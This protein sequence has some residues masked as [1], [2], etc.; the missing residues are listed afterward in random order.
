MNGKFF[1]Y[2]LLLFSFFW[3]QQLFA[4]DEVKAVV[5]GTVKNEADNQRMTGVNVRVF[6]NGQPYLNLKTDNLGKYSTEL[7]L[8][9]TYEI[10][11]EQAEFLSK[12]ILVD[13]QN[14]PESA[15]GTSFDLLFDGTLFKGPK[16]FNKDVLKE[17]IAKAK[18]TD[19]NGKI[20]VDEGH[21][22]KRKEEIKEEIKRLGGD[23][24]QMEKDFNQL[25]IEGDAKMGASKWGE[26]VDKYSAA[27]KIFPHKDPAESKYKD[28]KAKFDAE[29]DAKNFE[30]KY[31]LL[32]KDG[33][34]LFAQDKYAESKVKFVEANKMKPKEVHP[35]E[36]LAELEGLLAGD[37]NKAEYDRQ[38]ADAD[39]KFASKFYQPAIDAYKSAS[40]LLPEEKYPK[41]KI[42]ECE[43]LIADALK[44]RDEDVKYQRLKDDA[45]LK[46]NSKKYEEAI[47]L[48]E[49]AKDVKPKET[50]P[51]QQIVKANDLIKDRDYQILKRKYDE[52]VARGDQKF[53]VKDFEAS[54]PIYEEAKAVLP[55]ELVAGEKI[56]A[57]NKAI[58]DRD[59][60]KKRKEYTDLVAKA[61]NQFKSTDFEQAVLNYESALELYASEVYPKTQIIESKRLQVEK[62]KKENQKAY[63]DLVAKADAK[64]NVEN[65][66]ESI[67]IYEQASALLT[68]EKYPGLQIVKANE[69]IVKRDEKKLRAQFDA[70]VKQADEKFNSS[71]FEQSI[72]IYNQALAVLGSEKY[73]KDQITKAQEGITKR[74]EKKLRGEFDAIVKQADEK[75]NSNNY[76]QSIDTYNQALALLPSEKYPKD[77]ITKAQEGITKRDE[78]KL[79]GEFDAIVQQADEK[80]NSGIYEQSIDIYNQALALLPS[81]KYPKDQITKAMGKMDALAAERLKKEQ[82]D[83]LLLDGDARLAANEFDEC[84][85][86]YKSAGELFPKEIYPK[87][88]IKKAESLIADYK[89]KKEDFDKLV[90]KGDGKFNG[91]K[92][93]ESIDIYNQALLLLP[94]ESYPKEQIIAATAKMDVVAAEKLKRQ[95]YDE[96][97][98]E[99]DIKYKN[100]DYQMAS[101]TYQQAADLYSDELYPP[102]QI[103][104]CLLMLNAPSEI[105]VN[106]EPKP[107]KLTTKEY[108]PRQMSRYDA[109]IARQL[110]KVEEKKKRNKE[111]YQE[112]SGNA[113]IGIAERNKEKQEKKLKTEE[114]IVSTI[115]IVDEKTYKKGNETVTEITVRKAENYSTYRKAAKSFATYYSEINPDTGIKI[116][117][118]T[119]QEWKRVTGKDPDK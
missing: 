16:D 23:K 85:T 83:Q 19:K 52:I 66:E 103:E 73:P 33:D 97:V 57:A 34:A 119:A 28:A 44:T 7:E 15:R 27:L 61:D 100:R 43:G 89:K 110:A 5:H 54:I 107:K 39:K 13:T 68:S 64:F 4:Q 78:K 1:K 8:G 105:A 95:R 96:L 93:Q 26:A 116:R 81:E 12:N 62:L 32:V 88:Q 22:E 41:D 80:Y 6:K 104:K 118:L 79:R 18:F 31:A 11:F 75:F 37:K 58:A 106:T 30:E 21:A 108:K 70:I 69:G 29:N 113:D 9:Y 38:I 48:Y 60:A 111:F 17:P 98:A 20:E 115:N 42:A 77:Q 2:G 72:D 25:V 90:S 74:D 55:K 59:E 51:D 102:A 87:E 14:I 40:K 76:E 114:P 46:L 109:Y 10:R 50:Y 84:I 35:K 24:V 53:N 117:D 92:W 71:N 99:A 36:R 56:A 65:F 3:V 49:Q 67:P 101:D 91:E 63:D 112:K 45:D 86:I 94:N 47:A 82:Y